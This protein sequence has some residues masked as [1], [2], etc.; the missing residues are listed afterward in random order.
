[1]EHMSE[2]RG[3]QTL[4]QESVVQLRQPSDRAEEA[5]VI[6]A[7]L[8]PQ[9]Q[10]RSWGSP[11]GI[12]SEPFHQDRPQRGHQ[13]AT[14]SQPTSTNLPKAHFQSR[15][16]NPWSTPE[17]SNP[18]HRSHW[19]TFTE[20]QRWPLFGALY[21]AAPQRR[22]RA[23]KELSMDTSPGPPCV[24]VTADRCYRSSE[25][26]DR[27]ARFFPRRLQL[28]EAG[29]VHGIIGRI[30]GQQHTGQQTGEGNCL[31]HMLFCVHDD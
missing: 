17:Q 24:D 1:M 31:I 10:T 9:P 12:G 30:L 7:E 20:L 28:W 19:A 26:L 27:N 16:V 21:R 3:S 18:R 5:V 14:T 29:E 15:W 22:P 23:L 6:T 4:T 25:G 13:D 11:C 8:T 2:K